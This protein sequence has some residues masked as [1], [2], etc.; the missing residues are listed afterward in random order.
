M[1]ISPQLLAVIK[2]LRWSTGLIMG[3]RKD[4]RHFFFRERHLAIAKLP[5]PLVF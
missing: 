3:F 1:A 2:R 5:L 4:G